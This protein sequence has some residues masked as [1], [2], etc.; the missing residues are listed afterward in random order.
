MFHVGKV[1]KKKQTAKINFQNRLAYHFGCFSVPKFHSC[2]IPGLNSILWYLRGRHT[3]RI[4]INGCHDAMMASPKSDKNKT[5]N[6]GFFLVCNNQLRTNPRLLC[7]ETITMQKKTLSPNRK[8]IKTR[9]KGCTQH[10]APVSALCQLA[11]ILHSSNMS[12]GSVPHEPFPIIS[13]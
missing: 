5:T 6:H 4:H 9:G 2:H 13:S 7:H 11:W 12:H 1:P 3:E 8:R 10:I